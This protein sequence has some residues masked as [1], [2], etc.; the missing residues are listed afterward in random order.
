[1]V[2]AVREAA[3]RLST[4]RE[5]ARAPAAGGGGVDTAADAVAAVRRVDR[6]LEDRLLPHEY[7]EEH[8]LYPALAGVLGGAEATATMSRAHAEIERLARRVRTHLDLLGPEAGEF[9]PEQVVDLRA[10]LYGLH[11]VLRM[12]FAQ[13]EESYF[14]MI[15]TDPVPT[16]PASPGPGH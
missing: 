13:E 15:P 4:A 3:D 2:E 16:D 6:L 12:H 14:S 11:T 9:P 5:G 8:E 10:V 1:V 7:A